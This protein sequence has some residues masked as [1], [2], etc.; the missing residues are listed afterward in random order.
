MPVLAHD[1]KR[2]L[3]DRTGR[4]EMIGALGCVAGLLHDRT[5]RLEKI[6]MT[7]PAVAKLHDRT[8]RLE[9]SRCIA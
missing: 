2:T 3:H 9:I 5:G 6:L 7:W 8:G 1:L 4:L